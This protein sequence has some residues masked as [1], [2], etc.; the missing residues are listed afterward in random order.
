MELIK[1]LRQITG[2]GML[3]CQKALKETNNDLNKAVELLRKRGIAK[4]SKR[5]TKIANEGLI[6]VGISDNKTEGYIFEINSETD[7]VSRNE[8]FQSL[9]NNVLELAKKE[10]PNT[11]EALLSI[12][13]GEGTVEDDI[14]SLSGTIGEKMGIK[15]FARLEGKTVTAYSHPGGR[16]GVIVSL[17]KAGQDELALDIAMHI[18]AADPK[19]ISSDDVPSEEINKEK[20]IYR[21]QLLKEGKPENIIDKILEGKV[22]KYYSEVCLLDQEFIKDDKQKIKDILGDIKV[23][24]FVRY[25]L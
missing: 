25:S 15:H 3:D 16:M 12:Q 11:L 19:Y 24:K 17:D 4:A 1:Q 7:F 21:A 22:N 18:A 10:K 5:A 13:D 23:N 20:E 9:A 6:V 8:K 14:A 2:V